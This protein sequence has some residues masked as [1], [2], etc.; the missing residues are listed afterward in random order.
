[1]KN[2]IKF[3]INGL[4]FNLAERHV[5][6]SDYRG[7]PLAQPK[8][9]MSHAASA[10][11]IKQYVS[12]TY[13]AVTCQVSSS[14]FAGGNSVDVY[15]SDERGNTV[16]PEIKKDVDSFG[17]LFVYGH[18]N[19]ME[20]MYEY[21]P[22]RD[23][24]TPEGYMIDASLKYLSVNNKPKHASLPSVYRMITDMMSADSTYSFGQQ[25]A[26]GAIKWA[27]SFGATDKLVVKAFEMIQEDKVSK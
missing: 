25:D 14:S 8:L 19:G 4:E 9:Y 2:K 15:L 23:F 22:D 11:V 24:V 27:K 5:H 13:P 21:R 7:N 3:T 17:H 16:A 10:S 12:M 26:E 18:F 1:M 20:D 6:Q